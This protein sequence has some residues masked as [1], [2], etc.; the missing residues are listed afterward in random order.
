MG[1][2]LPGEYA[3]EIDSN[4][5]RYWLAHGEGFDVVVERGRRLGVVKDVV[6]NPVTQEVS[7]VVVRRPMARRAAQVAIDDLTVVLPASRRFLVTPDLPAV[8][9]H[10]RRERLRALTLRARLRWWSLR[11][12]T[13]GAAHRSTHALATTSDDLHARWPAVRAALVAGTHW[14]AR[15]SVTVGRAA[16]RTVVAVTA[17]IGRA[18]FVALVAGAIGTSWAVRTGRALITRAAKRL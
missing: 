17:A 2:P 12:A 10:P 5:G 4:V 11:R 3:F 13:R 18:V 16:G 1:G 14:S 7:G 9:H 8:T 15:A 6:V